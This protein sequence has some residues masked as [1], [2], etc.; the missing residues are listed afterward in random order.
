MKNLLSILIAVLVLCGAV[1]RADA[2]QGRVD[3][4]VL[5]GVTVDLQDV[6]TRSHVPT[7][8]T[9]GVLYFSITN[10][11]EGTLIPFTNLTTAVHI[12]LPNPTNNV[13]R[14]FTVAP[15]GAC[16]VTLSNI[17]SGTFTAGETRA[18]ATTYTVASNRTA[19]VYSTGTNYI[20]FT[21]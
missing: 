4:R 8:L 9:P 18:V 12:A 7:F 6:Y 11:G 16:T 19:V 13:G 1:S 14:K 15:M 10:V 5:R 21:Q 17:V 2:A 3:T 20:A